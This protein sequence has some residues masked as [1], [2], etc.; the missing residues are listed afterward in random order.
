MYQLFAVFYRNNSD[1][2]VLEDYLDFL[3][4]ERRARALRYRDPADRANCIL[5]YLLLRYA[6]KVTF[7]LGDPEIERGENG[8]PFLPEHPNIHFNLSHCS[9]GCVVG[10]SDRPIG[11]DIQN[12]RPFSRRL[13]EYCCAESEREQIRGAADPEAEFARIWAMKE[14]CVKMT[15]KGITGRMTAID[16]TALSHQTKVFRHEECFIAVTEE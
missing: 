16:T 13:M 12:V 8:K 11:V 3:P 6:L 4:A 9:A 15:G 14:S 7:F 5:S 1:P 2:S 10:V